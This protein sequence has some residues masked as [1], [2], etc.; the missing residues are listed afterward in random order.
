MKMSF[1]KS[2]KIRGGGNKFHNW[3]FWVKETNPMYPFYE[4]SFHHKKVK[5]IEIE[6]K[7]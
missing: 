1:F 2:E 5:T 3:G 4:R 7:K 6:D